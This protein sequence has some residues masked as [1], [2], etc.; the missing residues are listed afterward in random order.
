MEK[1]QRPP[2]A[3]PQ[4]RTPIHFGN[5]A[6]ATSLHSLKEEA[7]CCVCLEYFKNPVSVECGHAFCLSCITECWKGLTADFPCPQC[8]KTS[9]DNTFRPSWQL[10]NMVEIA[11][12]LQVPGAK[13]TPQKENPNLCGEHAEEL[14]L[15]CEDDQRSICVVCRESRGHKA[16][17]VLPMPEAAQ[18][19]KGKFKSCLNTLRKK[20][21]SVNVLHSKEVEKVTQ[22]KDTFKRQREL[23]VCEFQKLQQFLEKEKSHY[24]SNLEEEGKMTLQCIKGNLIKWKEQQ[25]SLGSVIREIESKCQQPDVELLKDVKSLLSR[26]E[27]VNAQLLDSEEEEEVQEEQTEEEEDEEVEEEKE[28]DIQLKII[29][30]LEWRWA[31]GYSG[32]VTLDPDT[33]HPCLVVSKDGKC[34]RKTD[35]AQDLPDTPQRFNPYPCILGKE[36]L[37]SG[38]HYWEVEVG[39]ETEWDLGVS[40]ELGSR[41][42]QLTLSPEGGFWTVRLWNGEYWAATSPLSPLVPRVRPRVLGFFVDYEADRLSVYNVQDRSLLFTFS[43]TSFPLTLQP[44]FCKWSNAGEVRILPGTGPV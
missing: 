34:V 10:R 27:N 3:V 30:S 7:T 28:E 38:R 2:T 40:D 8:R 19:Y 32:E 26:Y 24:L 33:A 43:E 23:I 44:L 4:P 20:L 41:K 9:Q 1:G 39:A 35:E 12:Q 17:K 25:N 18:E 6:A 42:G 5:M 11:K 15:Y 16:H 22:L 31:H 13:A 37:S 29:R 14:K 36:R 21:E